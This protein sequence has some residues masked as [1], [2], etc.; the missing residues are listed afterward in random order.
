MD[1]ISVVIDNREP[2]PHP[3]VKHWP[4]EIVVEWGTIETGD[5]CLSI[6]REH[7]PIVERKTGSDFLGC[8]GNNRER[9]EAELKRSR[10]CGHFVIIVEDSLPGL[11]NQTR[12]LSRESIIGSI[13]AWSRAYC[14][15]ILAGSTELAAQIA[16][17]WLL[18]P[19]E[20]A[21]KVSR[22]ITRDSKRLT[23]APVQDTKR[24]AAL[25]DGER[26]I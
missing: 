8:V 3:W 11:L 26:E 19:L 6:L 17:R 4:A 25:N 22:K 21:E 7:G 1:L 12:L 20:K 23:L 16:L 10:M 2:D 5:L 9:F 18:Q 14:P 15:V 13:A 24:I